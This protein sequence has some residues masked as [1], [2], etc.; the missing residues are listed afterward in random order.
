MLDD[1]GY[2]LTN[3]IESACTYMVGRLLW[4]WNDWDDDYDPTL[5]M[6]RKYRR[7]RRIMEAEIFRDTDGSLSVCL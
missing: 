5:I 6:L 3:A 4:W 7:E 2:A 1:I